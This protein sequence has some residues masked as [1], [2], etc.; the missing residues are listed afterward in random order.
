MQDVRNLYQFLDWKHTGFPNMMH[1]SS[2][3][4]LACVRH[5]L[6]RFRM[7]THLVRRLIQIPDFN[8]IFAHQPCP[9]VSFDPETC[10]F[11]EFH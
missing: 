4:P 9:S 10:G 5:V 8:D 11:V 6:S 3:D 1:C 7:T 2:G